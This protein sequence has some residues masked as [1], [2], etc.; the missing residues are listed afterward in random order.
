[1]AASNEPCAH[2]T[3]VSS[4]MTGDEAQSQ[5]PAASTMNVDEGHST[6][7]EKQMRQ[8]AGVDIAAERKPISFFLAFMYLPAFYNVSG[9]VGI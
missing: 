6:E 2:G 1:M 4:S 7:N 5:T 9:G 3:G 8:T